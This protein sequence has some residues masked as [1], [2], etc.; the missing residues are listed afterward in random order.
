MVMT[1]WG[2]LVGGSMF[3][4]DWRHAQRPELDPATRLKSLCLGSTL[5]CLCI[6]SREEHTPIRKS[7]PRREGEK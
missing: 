6:R 3:T 7:L 5:F 4:G 1:K 2:F